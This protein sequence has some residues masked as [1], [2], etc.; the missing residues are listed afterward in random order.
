MRDYGILSM[1]NYVIHLKP[2]QIPY[3]L[4]NHLDLHINY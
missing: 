4:I 2:N 1:E 3:K